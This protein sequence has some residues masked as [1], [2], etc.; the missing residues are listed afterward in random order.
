M[1]SSKE[2]RIVY[3][4]QQVNKKVIRNGI[5]CENLKHLYNKS[6]TKICFFTSQANANYEYLSCTIYKDNLSESNS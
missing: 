3:K 2:R 6:K 4:S 1:L 5:N